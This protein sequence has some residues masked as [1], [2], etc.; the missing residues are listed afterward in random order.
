MPAKEWRTG[1]ACRCRSLAKS[2]PVQVNGTTRKVVPPFFAGAVRPPPQE[3][4][5]REGSWVIASGQIGSA[6]GSYREG[7]FQG[8]SE[9][10]RHRTSLSIGGRWCVRSRGNLAEGKTLRIIP[11]YPVAYASREQ[12]RQQCQGVSDAWLKSLGGMRPAVAGRESN[13]A[14]SST[15]AFSR[16]RFSTE[17]VE[18]SGSVSSRCRLRSACNFIAMRSS[19]LAMRRLRPFPMSQ[20]RLSPRILEKVCVSASIKSTGSAAAGSSTKRKRVKFLVR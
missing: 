3:A 16:I 5:I 13:S 15:A 17:L 10:A 20:R 2:S 11:G 6:P 18:D 1:S 8:E 12:R 19:G 9:T 4:E 7:V 14:K